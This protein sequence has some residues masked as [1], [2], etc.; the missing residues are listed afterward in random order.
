[1]EILQTRAAPPTSGSLRGI[2]ARRPLLAFFILAYAWAWGLIGAAVLG[3]ISG[4]VS[5]DAP[6]VAILASLA[7][8]GPAIA[9]LAIT[10]AID[11]RAGLRALLGSLNPRRVG[12]GWYALA[13]F[14]PPLAFVLVETLVYGVAPL[15]ALAEQ[16][17]LIFTRYLPNTVIVL[18]FTGIAEELGW[19]GFAQSRLQ[20]HRGPIAGTLILGAAA[21]LWHLPNAVLQPGGPATFGLTALYTILVAFLLAWAYNRNQGSVLIVALMH[22]ALNSSAGLVGALVPTGDRVA[23]I[24]QIYLVG[25]VITAAVTVLLVAATRGRLGAPPRAQ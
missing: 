7:P 19:R 11:R 4:A 2:F 5:E 1:M 17:P 14:G 24:Q 21:A 9:A 22:A 12:L 3:S 25:I 15:A 18:V 20:Q 8:F 10:A 23:Y 16:W 6:I 13:L